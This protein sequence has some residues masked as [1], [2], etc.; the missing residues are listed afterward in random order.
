MADDFKDRKIPEN[1]AAS[2]VLLGF[3]ATTE[4]IFD[5]VAADDQESDWIFVGDCLQIAIEQRQVGSTALNNTIEI[6]GRIQTEKPADSDEGFAIGSGI[7]NAGHYTLSVTDRNSA[8]IIPTWLKLKT[9][10]T[11]GTADVFMKRLHF[12]PDRRDF[13]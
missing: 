4:K 9:N 12:G 10:Y 2:K 1:H 3:L 11:A 6:R 13:G 8:A 7:A 5:E